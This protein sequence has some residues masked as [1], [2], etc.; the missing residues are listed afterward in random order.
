MKYFIGITRELNKE[1]LIHS[2]TIYTHYKNIKR[3]HIICNAHNIYSI[4]WKSSKNQHITAIIYLSAYAK[5]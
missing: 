2:Y 3:A 1:S 5:F 4:I